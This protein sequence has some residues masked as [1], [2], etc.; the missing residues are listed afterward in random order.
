MFVVK[1]KKKLFLSCKFYKV[2]RMPNVVKETL[3]RCKIPTKQYEPNVYN[4]I[5]IY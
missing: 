1:K 5:H 2:P 4:I 3:I